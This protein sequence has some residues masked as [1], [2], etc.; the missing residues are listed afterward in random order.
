[1]NTDTLF[2]QDVISYSLPI[3]ANGTTY[4][5]SSF[6]TLLARADVI[7]IK[8]TVQNFVDGIYTPIIQDSS[9]NSV[10]TDVDDLFLRVVDRTVTTGQEE[11]A[12]LIANGS[13]YMGY[14]PQKQYFKAGVVASGVTT[15]ATV[16]IT[17]FYQKS[18]Q[19]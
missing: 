18:L 16:V 15:G 14:V 6:N 1:M 19:S 8:Y 11:A 17:I 13:T 10:F 12:K 9:N 4:I 7:G 2:S 3:T 5:P